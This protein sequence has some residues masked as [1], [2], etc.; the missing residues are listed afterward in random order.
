MYKIVFFCL[1]SL[2]AFGLTRAD[3]TPT[4]K[5]HAFILD[6]AIDSTSGI[7][8]FSWELDTLALNIYIKKKIKGEKDFPSDYYAVL[9]GYSVQFS[10]SGLSKGVSY[11]YGFEKYCPKH[12][13]WAYHNVGYSIAA[14]EY[15]GRLLL[16]VD[17]TLFDSLR[18]EIY[19][20]KRNMIGDGWRVV[21][22]NAPRS[23]TFISENVVK[24]KDIILDEYS[25]DSDS[26]EAIFIIGRV[27]IPYSGNIAIDGHQPDHLGAWPSDCFYGDID[28]VWTDTSLIATTSATTR[29]FNLI[30]DGKFDQSYIPSDIDLQVGR[31]DFSNLLVYPQSEVELL[32]NYIRKNNDYRHSYRSYQDNAIIDDRFQMQTKDAFGSSPWMNFSAIVGRENIDTGAIREILLQKRYKYAYGC[33][34]G[35]Y[36]GCH[37]IGYSDEYPNAPPQA[38][39]YGLIGSYYGDWDWQDNLLRSA[40]ASSSDIVVAYWAGRPFWHLHHLGLG[41]TWGYSTR[42]T[43]NNQLNYESS[44]IWGNRLIHI[45]LLGDPTLRAHAISAPT[46][47]TT[48][49][50]SE[51]E[52][53]LKWKKSDDNVEGYIVYRADSLEGKFQRI[54][55]DIIRVNEFVD[56]NPK[57]GKNTYMVRAIRLETVPSGSY[58]NLSQGA[59]SEIHYLPDYISN[60]SLKV[61]ITSN[62]VRENT[63]IIAYSN[64]ERSGKID[65]FDSEGKV[66]KSLFDGIIDSNAKFISYDL[67]D[68]SGARLAQ[69][70]YFIRLSSG[71][72]SSTAKL[73]VI[74]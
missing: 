3:Y 21:V 24:V 35:A 39:F 33:N 59:F 63:T 11:E 40:L 38:A 47:L 16:L 71:D 73:L 44:N 72:K 20:L 67:T 53:E 27:A 13:A 15:R 60:S 1:L 8:N 55:N 14:D 6:V 46:E 66:V 31:V 51:N 58:Y 61:G 26:L 41:E 74:D 34:M 32:R 17:E 62:P 12:S 10:D 30:G 43:Q 7:A 22:R 25:S 57:L 56:A 65:L 28:G 19:L 64:V 45:T 70:V 52:I 5:D 37:L 9:D 23:D 2:L 18:N 29:Q 54:S 49:I 68:Q 48:A 50:N 4:S 69:G 42:L 36:N